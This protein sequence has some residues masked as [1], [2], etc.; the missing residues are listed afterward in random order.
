MEGGGEGEE[1]KAWGAAEM[2]DP[3]GAGKEKGPAGEIA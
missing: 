2:L 1:A 3:S